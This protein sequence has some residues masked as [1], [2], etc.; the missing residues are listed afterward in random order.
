LEQSWFWTAEWQE[1]EKEAHADIKAG[2]TKVFPDV[3]ELL[4][5]LDS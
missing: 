3:D 1:A 5:E 4:E 2:K